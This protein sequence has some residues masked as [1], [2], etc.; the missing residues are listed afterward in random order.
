MYHFP[1]FPAV[2]AVPWG[3]L[4]IMIST[5]YRFHGHNSLRYVYSNGKAQR[6]QLFTVKYVPNARRKH[7]RFSI[8]VSKKVIKS[9]VGRNRIR[10]RLYEYVR[11][12]MDRLDGVYDIV[13]I[14]TSA[15]L[16][17]LPYS[18]IAEQLDV[19]FT[20]AALYKTPEN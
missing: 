17:V 6:S 2:R 14:C 13:I 20:K 1:N 12:N 16:R 4:D 10:R 15:E 3:I 5:L 8:V 18:Q 9:A 19:L 11:L 7:P